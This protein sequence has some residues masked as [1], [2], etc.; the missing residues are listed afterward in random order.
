MKKTIARISIV[1]AMGIGLSLVPNPA[2]AAQPYSA[3][4][5]TAKA[6]N[7]PL[8]A[9]PMDKKSYRYTSSFG[10]RCPVLVGAG[11][12]HG[13]ID[14]AAPDGSPLY[15]IYPGKVVNIVTPS[16]SRTPTISIDHGI[17]NGKK[18]IVSYGH[19]WN[20]TKYVQQGST[21]KAGQRIGDVGSA[22]ISNGPHVHFY[23]NWGDQPIDPIP[24]LKGAGIDIVA[25]AQSVTTKPNPTS[26]VVYTGAKTALKSSTSWE[27]STKAVLPK[28]TKL[29]IKPGLPTND[30]VYVTSSA[31]GTGYVQ[32]SILSPTAVGDNQPALTY[33]PGPKN[34]TITPLGSRHLFDY[35]S[36]N[37]TLRG[38]IS[39]V[40]RG[41]SMVTTGNL[42]GKY[43]EVKVGNLT[44]WIV[45]E[46]V[47]EVYVPKTFGK[48]AAGS[49]KSIGAYS[50]YSSPTSEYK[51]YFVTYPHKLA[52]GVKVTATGR[53]HGNFMEV[54]YKN[55]TGWM[56]KTVL[57][58]G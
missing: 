37:A 42:F 10:P 18:L 1:L 14:L 22:G 19:M 9:W 52:A 16:G 15:A 2:A 29:T 20:P 50:I 25:N 36:D 49:Y 56:F 24:F 43:T 8:A 57:K 58:R 35:P 32:S 3:V 5:S 17:I 46:S 40:G 47:M 4:E 27:S 12:Y 39:T 13:A 55:T 51:K 34:K 11:T 6:A 30:L 26:C 54:K 45:A 53:T 44:G 33:K 31:S 21:V 41:V 7:A 38:V 48:I 23:M 28:N